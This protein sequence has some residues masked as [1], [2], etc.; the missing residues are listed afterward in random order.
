MVFF[1]PL[2]FK[3][4]PLAAGEECDYLLALK[5]EYRAAMK[6]SPYYIKTPEKKKDIERYSD[7]YQLNGQDSNGTWQPG[8]NTHFNCSSP[9]HRKRLQSL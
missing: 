5:Q 4:V 7:K 8:K 9:T 2:E 1:Q 3:P 6:E